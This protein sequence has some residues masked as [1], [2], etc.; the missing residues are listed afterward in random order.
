MDTN[1]IHEKLNNEGAK[2]PSPEDISKKVVTTPKEIDELLD[3]FIMGDPVEKEYSL[4]NKIN[5][6][7]RSVPERGI[8]NSLSILTKKSRELTGLEASSYYNTILVSAYVVKFLT[9]TKNEVDFTKEKDLYSVDAIQTRL[10]Y[11]QDRLNVQLRAYVVTSVEKFQDLLTE[12]YNPDSL[13]N[14]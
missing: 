4:R 8:T 13:I 9:G 3:C 6:T 5:F 2:A 10:E 7:I 1:K 12:V 14:F 11:F